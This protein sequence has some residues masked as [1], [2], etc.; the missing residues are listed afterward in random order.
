MSHILR[1]LGEAALQFRKVGANKW[2]PPVLSRRRAMVIRKEWLAQGKEWP[3]EHLVPG[4][5]KNDPPFNGGKQRGHKRHVS[6]AERQAKI[7]AAM[8]KMP[9]AIAE[10]RASRRIPWDAVSPADRLLLTTR[11]IREK[12]VYKKLK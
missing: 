12:Y 4:V 6:Q 3:Y 9:A 7:D 11:Q 1:R 10:Y 2:L 8:A 5:P